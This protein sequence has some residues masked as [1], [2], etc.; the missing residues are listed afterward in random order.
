MK[1]QSRSCTP[2]ASGFLWGQIG[3]NGSLEEEEWLHDIDDG[4]GLAAVGRWAGDAAM[5]RL[6]LVGN[7]APHYGFASQESV[8]A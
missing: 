4:V 8:E 3:A 1:P 5:L 7:R 6:I 2:D